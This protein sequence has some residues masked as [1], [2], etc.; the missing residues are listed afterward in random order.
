MKYFVK[1]F[2][3]IALVAV[4]GFSFAACDDGTTSGDGGGNIPGGNKLGGDDGGGLGGGS[5]GGDT[6]G[7]TTYSIGGVWQ[8]GSSGI[9]ITI[10]GNTGVYKET[11]NNNANA[12]WQS[13][14]S[15]GYVK[16]GDTFMKNLNKTGNLTWTGQLIGI[17][18]NTSDPN[19]ATGTGWFN[20]CTYTMNV[21]GQTFEEYVPDTG[22]K[23]TYTRQ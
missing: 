9:I 7:T 14:I 16:V 13:A 23:T 15:K 20:N 5:G 8:R 3:I 22:N 19:V 21:N 11:D 12:L 17:S 1:W 6:G 2:S 4:I 18:Y 10:S